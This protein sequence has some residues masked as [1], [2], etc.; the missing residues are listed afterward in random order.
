VLLRDTSGAYAESGK[1][2]GALVSLKVDYCTHCHV[3]GL[4]A[5]VYGFQENL[6]GILVCCEHGIVTREGTSKDYWLPYDMYRIIA[7]ND[8][9]FPISAKIQAVRD[10]V[11]PGNFVDAKITPRIPSQSMTTLTLEQQVRL[12][13]QRVALARRDIIGDED[14]K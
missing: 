7:W 1:G 13:R 2:I 10:K 11:L 5:I 3:Q 4:L 8:S 6:G 9:T 12:K 14:V